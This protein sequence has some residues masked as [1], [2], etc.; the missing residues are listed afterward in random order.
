VDMEGHVTHLFNL[1]E[2]PYEQTNLANVSAERLKRD[3]W[4]AM[5]RLWMKKLGDGVDASG[6]KKR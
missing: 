6:L 4:F 1:A 3:S 5:Q 2:D